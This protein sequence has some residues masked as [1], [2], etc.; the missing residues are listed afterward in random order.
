MFR[1]HDDAMAIH[2][3]WKVAHVSADLV[4]IRA[5]RLKTLCSQDLT[6]KQDKKIACVS[7]FVNNI[8]TIQQRGVAAARWSLSRMNCQP[9]SW[10]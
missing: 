7:P 8:K 6:S 5:K 10:E 9:A 1:L 4:K 2:N 3:K